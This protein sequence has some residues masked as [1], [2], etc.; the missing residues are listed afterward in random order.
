MTTMTI[1]LRSF[2]EAKAD[3]RALWISPARGPLYSKVGTGVL[4]HGNS[5]LAEALAS[6]RTGAQLIK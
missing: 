6:L 4:P 5:F 1:A 2:G 3:V